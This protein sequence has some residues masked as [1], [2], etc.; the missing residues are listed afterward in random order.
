[1]SN[2]PTV[3][4]ARNIAVGFALAAAPINAPGVNH[5]ASADRRC[6]AP[7]ESS[8]GAFPRH[9]ASAAAVNSVTAIS[10][11]A[12]VA[13]TITHGVHRKSAPAITPHRRAHARAVPARCKA[14]NTA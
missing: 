2:N 3:G 14:R 13:V 9:T 1:S 4:A 8:P 6:D 7:S 5:R 12:S 10:L 11:Y